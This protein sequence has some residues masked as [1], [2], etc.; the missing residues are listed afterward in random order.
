MKKN[1]KIFEWE[2]I[3]SFIDGKPNSFSLTE[4]LESSQD[5]TD[6]VRKLIKKEKIVL[7]AIQL[8]GK[9]I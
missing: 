1:Q 3:L 8:A 2:E 7:I 9:L 5:K 6:I 4:F